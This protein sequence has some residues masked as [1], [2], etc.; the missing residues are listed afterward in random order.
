MTEQ[1]RV[2]PPVFE[3]TKPFGPYMA[4]IELPE[5]VIVNLTKMTDDLLENPNTPSHGENLAGVIYDEKKIYQQ[6]FIDAG[7]SDML[8]GCVRTYVH[9]SVTLGGF[10][11]D[12]IVES[13]IN[14]AW[15]VSQYE[16]EYNPA[17]AHTGC[18]I[19]GVLYLKTPDVKGR[20]NIPTKEGKRDMDSDIVFPYNSESQR[21]GEVLSKAI[22]QVSPYR[23]L[24]LLFPSW[25][26]HYVYP[27]IGEGE[28]RSIAFNGNYAVHRKTGKLKDG[29]PAHE[30][31]GGSHK[32]VQ[33]PYTYWDKTKVKGETK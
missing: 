30:W 27:F 9:Q 6:D 19:S 29:T 13:Q 23:G 2:Q 17:H 33:I 15:I 24:M 5:E 22:L 31:I 20:R 14:S 1:I 12:I 10:P 7:V 25:L 18:E 26:L 21:E 4:T 28:R 32:N 3:V 8:E 11:Q 16:N